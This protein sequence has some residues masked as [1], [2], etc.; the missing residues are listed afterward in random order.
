MHRDQ[1][2]EVRAPYRVSKRFIDQFVSLKTP[3]VQR[4]QQRFATCSPPLQ[5]AYHQGAQHQFLG[6]SVKLV[7][8][9]ENKLT[10]HYQAGELRIALP[11]PDCTAKVETSLFSWFRQQAK[12]LFTERVHYWYQEME[13]FRVCIA[14]SW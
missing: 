5:L 10:V 12:G 7:L 6:E 14:E 4:Q 2:I 13:G 8:T 1:R 11:Q 3:W 9:Q